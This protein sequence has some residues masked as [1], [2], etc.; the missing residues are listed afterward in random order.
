MSDPDIKGDM[1]SKLEP[2]NSMLLNTCKVLWH[3]SSALAVDEC[4]SRFTGRS[5]EKITIPSKPI[6]TGIKGWVIADEGYFM[7]WIWHAKGD[8]PQGIGKVPKPLGKNKTAA[9]VVYL[10]KTLPKGPPGTYSVTLDNLFTSTKLLVYLSAEGFG[11]RGTA[12]T[13][14]GI[15]QDLLDYK[16]SDKNDIISWGTTHLRYVAEGTVAQI[17]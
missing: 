5:K 17:G 7:Y 12:R 1:F 15:H 16:K 8:G 2:V 13:N 9:V 10:L 14:A 11:A 3:P 4:M 6:P